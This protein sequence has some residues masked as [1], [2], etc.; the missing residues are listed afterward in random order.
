MVLNPMREK[1]AREKKKTNPFGEP[2]R[3]K[4]LEILYS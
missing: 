2:T 4:P 3:K 1:G